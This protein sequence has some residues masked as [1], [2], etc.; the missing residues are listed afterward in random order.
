MNELPDSSSLLSSLELMRSLKIKKPTPPLADDSH[1]DFIRVC[2]F[3]PTGGTA[4]R[5]IA[6]PD[7][8]GR[9]G[10]PT[11]VSPKNWAEDITSSPTMSWNASTGASSY[12]LQVSTSTS[13]NQLVFEDSTISATNQEVGPI[14]DNTVYYW[15]VLA[16]NS[17]GSS[18]WSPVWSFTTGTNTSVE[19]I[20]T[21]I[22]VEFYFGNN[23]PNPFYQNTSIVYSIPLKAKVTIMLFDTWGREI[24]TLVNEELIAGKYEVK[25]DGSKLPEGIYFYRM[26]VGAYS[27]TRKMVLIK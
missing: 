7:P 10:S 25:V 1:L 11:L 18:L 19:Q 27:K 21:E 22:P 20:S 8:Y 6:I 26:Q 4:V 14:T 13:F 3:C 15:R 16:K 2:A 9:P 17:N 12:R 5:F 23:Y 24:A